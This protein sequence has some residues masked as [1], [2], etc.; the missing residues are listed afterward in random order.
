MANSHLTITI[1]AFLLLKLS[2]FPSTS[3]YETGSIKPGLNRVDVVVEGKVYCQS[4]DHFGSWSLTKAEPI[5]SAKI[6]VICKN[7]LKQV[8]FYKA[9][10]T[11]KNGYFYAQLDGFKIGSN[12][13]DHPLQSCKVKLV[14]SSIAHCSLLSNVNYGID[15]APLRFESKILRRN[16]YDVAVYAAGPLAFRPANCPPES[17]V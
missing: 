10:Q 11:D 17:H 3:A 2:Y 9:Y 5:P 7:Y 1:F 12:I 15:G 6:S 16:R 14:S 13:L 8:S 4:C